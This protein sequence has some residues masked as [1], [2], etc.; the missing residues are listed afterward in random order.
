MSYLLDENGQ[1]VTLFNCKRRIERSLD[2][3]IGLCKGLIADGKVTKSEALFLQQWLQTNQHV[4]DVWPANVIAARLEKDLSSGFSDKKEQSDLFQLLKKTVRPQNFEEVGQTPSTAL[5]FDDPC[6]SIRYEGMVFCFTGKFAFGSRAAC[7]SVALSLGGKVSSRITRSLDYLVV[8][9]FG[10]R[11]WIHS[12]HG[13][14][15]EQ[16]IQLRQSAGRL[17]IIPEEHW[18]GALP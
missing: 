6:P 7:E 18:A 12:S 5:P 13:R 16:A 9:L 10:S 11:D 14:K 3:L 15:I 2:E 1:P 8:G 4:M 17:A